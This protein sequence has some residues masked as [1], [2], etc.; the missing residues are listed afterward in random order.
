MWNMLT[1]YVIQKEIETNE[2]NDVF[3]KY[4]KIFKYNKPIYLLT[5]DPLK[6][7]SKS[8]CTDVKDVFINI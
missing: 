5:Y 3:F 2:G 1:I 7:E 4:E 8:N 6:I